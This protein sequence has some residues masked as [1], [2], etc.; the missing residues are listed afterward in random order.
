MAGRIAV[1]PGPRTGR[2]VRSALAMISD[3][4]SEFGPLSDSGL[5]FALGPP[6]VLPPAPLPAGTFVPAESSADA[7]AVPRAG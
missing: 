4:A 6:G 5:F 2:R 3:S 7:A 1:G